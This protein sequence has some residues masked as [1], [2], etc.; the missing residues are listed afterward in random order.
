MELQITNVNPFYKKICF[1]VVAVVKVVVVVVV[2]V[3]VFVAVPK[4]QKV[5]KVQKGSAPE[6]NSTI[7]N[8]DFLIRRGEAIFSFFPKC[9]CRL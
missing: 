8:V 5:E 1:V 3:V 6:I 4:S 2:H 7:Q 9:K